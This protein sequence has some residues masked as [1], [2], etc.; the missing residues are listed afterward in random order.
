MVSLDLKFSPFYLLGTSIPL[1]DLTSPSFKQTA[2]YPPF[3]ASHLPYDRFSL[4]PH[5][6]ISEL[7]CSGLFCPT[8]GWVHITILS[9][10]PP[11][12]HFLCIRN[13]VRNNLCLR[14][15]LSNSRNQK[16]PFTALIIPLTHPC[17]LGNLSKLRFSVSPPQSS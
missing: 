7:P 14:D 11:R 2:V 12:L 13:Q 17:H 6:L 16:L 9:P 3:S 10:P 8:V 4:T 15:P 1:P 5:S